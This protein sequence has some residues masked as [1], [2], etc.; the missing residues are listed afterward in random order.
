VSAASETL[1][2]TGEAGDPSSEKAGEP[3]AQQERSSS[4]R[5]NH[6]VARAIFGGV[7]AVA[8][9]VV[10]FVLL[11]AASPFEARQLVEKMGGILPYAA[12]AG[13]AG[14]TTVLALMLTAV[15][16]ARRAETT[17]RTTFYRRILWISRLS[18]GVFL[19]CVGVLLALITP[20][21]EID[22]DRSLVFVQFYVVAG[23]T[24]ALAGLFLTLI[25]ML[26]STV[27]D[28]VHIIGLRNDTH[29]LIAHEEEE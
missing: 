5:W 18:S 15:G 13:I 12:S 9:G 27:G 10:M 1:K 17:V 25:M 11:G 7:V 16:M 28:L 23:L 21:T 4:R 19:A 6:D 26:Q 20:V 22:G 8:F 2:S 24:A 3:S 14:S 29:P